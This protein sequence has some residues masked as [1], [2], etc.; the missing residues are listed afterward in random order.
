M[1]SYSEELLDRQNPDGGWGYGKGG[2]S[3]T[4]PTC[5]ALLALASGEVSVLAASR[6][7]VQWLTAG[8][9]SDGGLPPRPG[10]DQSTWVTALSLLMPAELSAG[11]DRQR[12]ADWLLAQS[13]RESGFVY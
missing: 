9:R 13:G 10:V 1:K 6:R 5:Y 3:W 7:G 2:T 4:E 12:A 11:P 8:Q